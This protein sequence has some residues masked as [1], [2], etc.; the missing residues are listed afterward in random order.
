[1]PTLADLLRQGSWNDGSTDEKR[2]LVDALR[3]TPRNEVLGTISDA[4][5]SGI[6]WMKSPERT[7]QMQ[8]LGAYFE[9]TG[10][11]KTTER[12]AYGEP[13]TNINKANVPLMKPETAEAIM[14]VAP[15]VP[16]A[17]FLPKN[18]PVGMSIK[19]VGMIDEL[20]G[21]PLNA[22]G[23]VTLFHHTNKSAAE[24]IAK[25][26]KLKSAGEPSVYLTTQK[27]TDTGYGDVAVPIRVKPSLLNLDDEFP[28]GR[29]DFSIDTGKPK[30]SIPVTVEK[31]SF[32]YPQEE[33]MRLAQQRAALPVE[34]GGLGLLSSNTAA[35]RA[36][37]MGFD[38][39][40]LHGTTNP[41]IKKFDPSLVGTK[42]GNAFDNYMWSTTSP[43]AATGYSLNMKSYESLP[44]VVN[45]KEQKND[46]L[47]Q[48]SKAFEAKDSEKVGELRK[49]LNSIHD[50]E[51]TISD[52]FKQGQILSEGSTV[53]PLA[54]QRQEFMP[55][56]ASGK[57]WMRANRPA[58]EQ[59]QD[60]GY[61]GVQINNVIDNPNS[62]MG[63][64]PA[65]TFAT[66]NPDLLRSRFAAFD[67]WRKTAATAAAMGVAAPD[68]LAK[69]RK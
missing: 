12:M 45:L 48:I 6:N 38:I 55:Y 30:G 56:E 41:N 14:N 42:A 11:P 33:A 17:K 36:K 28:S 16:A 69:E 23:T 31:P 4:M 66:E 25:T 29:M 19:P 60:L 3:A 64:A 43:D 51:I 40:S 39:E 58:I 22:D 49:Q 50:K 59:S 52:A 27:A 5:N 26:G 20:T 32:T 24:Q 63:S 9:S 2:Q 53:Y 34:E 37:A 62:F 13:L 1:M 47:K 54:L 15:L 68:L 44:E 65:T 67:P 18:V 57:N 61:Q 21:L 10:I 46:I 35:E 8:G 7:Q